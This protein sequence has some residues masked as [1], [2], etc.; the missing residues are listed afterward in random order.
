QA[1]LDGHVLG[2]QDRAAPGDRRRPR[3]DPEE[4]RAA[5]RVALARFLLSK[6]TGLAHGCAGLWK[7][8]ASRRGVAE[9]FSGFFRKSAAGTDFLR[10]F[11]SLSTLNPEP[12]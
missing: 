2:R 4:P 6:R 5:L 8:C 11:H 1:P 12:A 9:E 7:S 10:T 3:P